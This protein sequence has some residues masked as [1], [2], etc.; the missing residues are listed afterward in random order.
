M[1]NLLPKFTDSIGI[2]LYG[3]VCFKVNVSFVSI[4]KG[5]CMKGGKWKVME[6]GGCAGEGGEG[7]DSYCTR[8]GTVTC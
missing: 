2:R 4:R 1:F 3:L 5:R 8:Q 7:R 6:W